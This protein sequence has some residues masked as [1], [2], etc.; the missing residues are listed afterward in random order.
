[1]PQPED[2]SQCKEV[3]IKRLHK[4]IFILLNSCALKSSLFHV[5]DV[6]LLI[7]YFLTSDYLYNFFEN[8]MKDPLFI[9]AF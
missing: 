3:K 1:M 2:I 7:H 8:I 4:H 9:A 5:Y 6:L